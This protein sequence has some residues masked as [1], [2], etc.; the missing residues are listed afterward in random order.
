MEKKNF[1]TVIQKLKIRFNTNLKNAPTYLKG[2]K[3]RRAS[4]NKLT[5]LELLTFFLF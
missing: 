5:S 4:A 2:E 1:E 3:H